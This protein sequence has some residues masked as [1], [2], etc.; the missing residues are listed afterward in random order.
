MS[1]I[2]SDPDEYAPGNQP[3]G[4]YYNPFPDS[5]QPGLF[6]GQFANLQVNA[7]A[8]GLTSVEAAALGLD[9]TGLP[10]SITVAPNLPQQ[11]DPGAV[12]SRSNIPASFNPYDW[13][14]DVL[15]TPAGSKGLEVAQNA[16]RSFEDAGNK[17]ALVGLAG[18]GLFP[19]FAPES[20]VLAGLGAAFG[21]FGEAGDAV[22]S[23]LKS[24]Q[25]DNAKPLNDF[26]VRAATPDITDLVPD[27]R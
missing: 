19:P 5:S 18:A 14:H 16:A 4:S 6:G 22:T 15:N 13:A 21:G 9:Q 23:F 12:G 2:G 3:D 7:P 20:L 8:T 24:I 25:R 17:A 26:G 27:R 10:A 11:V 1:D